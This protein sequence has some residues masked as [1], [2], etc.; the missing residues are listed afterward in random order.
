MDNFSDPFFPPNSVQTNAGQQLTVSGFGAPDLPIGIRGDGISCNPTD[1]NPVD[2][3]AMPVD[4]TGMTP[5]D[6]T[7]IP[8]DTTDTTPVDTTSMPVDTTDM[9]PVDTTSMPVDTTDMTPCLL[10]TSP[11]PRDATLSRMPSSA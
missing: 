8:V 10:Y 2:T 7:N 9:T 4:T 1:T 11:S 5:V 3:T 6:T